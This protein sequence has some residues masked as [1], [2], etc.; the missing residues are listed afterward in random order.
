MQ[1]YT[2]TDV[3]KWN[4]TPGVSAI[5]Y[6]DA[7]ILCQKINI[8]HMGDYQSIIINSQRGSNNNRSIKIHELTFHWLEL[9]SQ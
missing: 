8:A 5:A 2:Y 9:T 6:Y 1:E 4:L 7:V 3:H